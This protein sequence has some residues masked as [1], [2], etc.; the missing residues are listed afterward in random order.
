MR[1]TIIIAA[2]LLP[3]AALSAQRPGPWLE[4]PQMSRQELKSAYAEEMT[5]AG[6]RQRNY[7]FLWN[8]CLFRC[9]YT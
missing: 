5:V 7:T 1:R 2:L 4:L 6:Q 9:K 8:E 3:C